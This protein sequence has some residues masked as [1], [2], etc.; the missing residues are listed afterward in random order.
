MSYTEKLETAIQKNQSTLCVG[1]DPVYAK[2]PREVTENSPDEA[3]AVIHFCK[4]VIDVTRDHCCAYKPNLGFFES[5]GEPAFEVLSEICSHIPSDKI[6]IADAKRGDI[7]STA[8]HYS[9]T[10]FDW[11]DADAV[12]V[13]PLMGFET[14]EPFFGYP[15]KALYVLTLTSNRGA[16]DFFL[17]P[18]A[19]HPSMSVY[20]AEHL[21][22]LAADRQTHLAM[23]VG[24]TKT[25]M[26][27]S[28][29]HTYPGGSLLIPGLGK[30]GGRVEDLLSAVTSP[31]SLPLINA[32]RSI[33]YA[34]SEQDTWYRSVREAAKSYHEELK[35]L[36]KQY[37]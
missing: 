30:Q 13:N 33:I 21:K 29:V 31:S 5:L 19:S 32:S 17:K 14:L 25:S 35:P 24:A 15:D 7:W 18:F 36:T 3:S 22:R 27:K 37:V 2:L 26:I 16:D 8:Q 12:T 34:F 9:K 1:L 20:I 11:L 6:I 28:I 4:Q 23:V 10:F